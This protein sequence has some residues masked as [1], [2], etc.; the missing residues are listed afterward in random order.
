M[1]AIT[2]Q[3]R[4]NSIIPGLPNTRQ[5]RAENTTTVLFKK[6]NTIYTVACAKPKQLG[7]FYSAYVAAYVFSSGVILG[8]LPT[9]PFS[10]SSSQ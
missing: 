8:Y 3:T 4:E 5:E 7:L 6:L 9:A 1:Q 2:C 10:P